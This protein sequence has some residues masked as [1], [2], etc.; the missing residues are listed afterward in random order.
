MNTKELIQKLFQSLLGIGLLSHVKRSGW[1]RYDYLVSIP[2]RY[3]S[4]FSLP[5]ML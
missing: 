1:K 3:Q 5:E 4:P 2:L